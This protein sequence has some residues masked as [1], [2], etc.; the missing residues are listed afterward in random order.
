MAD[1][2]FNTYAEAASFAKRRAQESGSSVK[3]E[4]RNEQWVVFDP[5]FP[6]QSDY[7][8]IPSPQQSS[9]ERHDYWEQ[10]RKEKEQEQKAIESWEMQKA[11]HAPCYACGGRGE[12]NGRTCKT[13][14]GRGYING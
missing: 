14:L 4:R 12:G 7:H 6:Q 5:G 10:W 9:V 13:C 3:F 8:P 1:M 2:T 11:Q